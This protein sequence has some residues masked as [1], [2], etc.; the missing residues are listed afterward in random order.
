MAARAALST[1]ELQREATKAFLGEA[2]SKVKFAPTS[3][4]AYHA[5]CDALQASLIAFAP[6]E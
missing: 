5:R 3:G 1:E 4:G 6:Q 2:A